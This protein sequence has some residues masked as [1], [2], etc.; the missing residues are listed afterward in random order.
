MDEQDV[1]RSLLHLRALVPSDS[2]IHTDLGD[3]HVVGIGRANSPPG[4]FRWHPCFLT[5]FPDRSDLLTKVWLGGVV[6]VAHSWIL[7]DLAFEPNSRA[8]S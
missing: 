5:Y 8:V 7:A 3:R 2:P 6:C 4:V 1:G